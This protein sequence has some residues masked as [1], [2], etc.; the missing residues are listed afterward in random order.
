MNDLLDCRLLKEFSHDTGLRAESTLK[1]TLLSCLFFVLT[2][3]I[4]FVTSQGRRLYL[5][6]CLFATPMTLLW[7]YFFPPQQV[8]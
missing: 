1:L 6:I 5:Q 8:N 2:T 4:L 7:M 3:M